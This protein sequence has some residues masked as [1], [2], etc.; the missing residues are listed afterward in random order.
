[1]S[2]I[3]KLTKL[4]FLGLGYNQIIVVPSIENLTALTYLVLSN[5]QI[6]NIDELFNLRVLSLVN[7]DIS[8]TDLKN[9]KTT[10]SSTDIIS[11]SCAN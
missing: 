4:T 5:N 1:M 2:P 9:L 7:D 6:I 3:N 11:W 8:C 10:L